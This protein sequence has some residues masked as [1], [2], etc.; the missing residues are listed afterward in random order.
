MWVSLIKTII[1]FIN[2]VL[3]NIRDN[4]M[5]S[6]GRFKLQGELT[7]EQREEE[8]ITQA[9][10]DNLNELS[11]DDFNKLYENLETNDKE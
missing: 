10:Q 9:Y 2:K 7:D 8:Q 5:I 1:E 11:D 6:L 3:G 4:R